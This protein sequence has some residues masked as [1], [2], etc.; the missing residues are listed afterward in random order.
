MKAVDGEPRQD[1]L[2]AVIEEV[3]ERRRAGNEL[4][5]ARFSGRGKHVQSQVAKEEPEENALRNAPG[6]SLRG[7]LQL[8]D[9]V[10]TPKLCSLAHSN[11]RADAT[12][13]KKMLPT[14]P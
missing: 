4:Q 6:R 7:L 11:T 14:I 13:T 9:H 1:S 8:S 5:Q 12:F 2:P 3:G 10:G